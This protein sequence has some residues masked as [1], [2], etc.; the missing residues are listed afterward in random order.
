MEKQIKTMYVVHHAH[1]DIGYT[2]LQERV[3]DTQAAYIREVVAMMGKPEYE[4]FR[5]NCET[6][7]CVEEFF[8]RAAPKEK[9]AFC[10]LAREGKLGVSA[11]YLNFTDLLDWEVYRKRLAK[12]KGRFREAGFD[13]K[14]A[15]CADINGISMGCRDAML[16]NG[17]EFLLMNINYSHGMYPLYQNQNAWWWENARGQ[18]LLVWNGE[19][20]N[21]GNVLGIKPNPAENFLMENHLGKGSILADPVETLHENLRYYRKLC[22]DN[23]HPY[24]FILASVSGVFSDN[25]PP[26]PEILKNIQAYNEKYGGECRLQ[27]VSLQELYEA[28]REKLADAPVYHGDLTDWWANGVGSAPYALKHYKDAVYR[29]ELA[30]RLDGRAEEHY[31]ELAR[32]VQD[33]LMLYAEHTGGH[34][35][36]VTDPY[37]TMVMNLDIRKNS[38]ASKAH[39]AAS[40]MLDAIAMEKGDILRYYASQGTIKVCSPS[41]IGGPKKVEFYLETIAF[42]EAVITDGT[43]RVIPSQVSAHPRGRRITFVDTFAPFEEKIYTY[44]EKKAGPRRFNSRRCYVGGEGVRDIENTYDPVSFRLPGAFENRWFSLS[45][46]P[47]EGITSFVDKR[48]GRNLLGEGTAP[49]FT[50]LYEQTEIRPGFSERDER[51]LRG[52]NIRGAHAKLFAGDLEQ[53]DCLERGDVF[54]VLCLRWRLPGTIRA[55]VVLKFYEEIPRIDFKL[56]LGKTLSLDMESVYLPMSLS[57]PDRTLALRKGTEAFR[58]GIDQVPGTC[59]DYYISDFGLACLSK[60]GGAL[61]AARDTALWYMGEMKHHTIRLCDGKKE[62]NQRPVYSWVMNNTWKTNFKIDLSGLGEY[63]YTLWLWNG[64]DMEEAMDA[65]KELSFDPYV[66]IIG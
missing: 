19:H 46:A 55:D 14:T 10:R 9:E 25:A 42:E 11:N 54:T 28:I 26:E 12:W 30:R 22:Q 13:L 27:M 50:P 38:Y 48:A 35:A 49:F 56:M 6:L 65:V 5:W 64:E 40:R 60:E 4:A 51:H 16:D 2:D 29:Y 18:R 61:I 32:T 63:C 7:F 15:M 3:A 44:R 62:N 21:L 24:D 17:I 39:E 59:M 52:R 45:Y 20:Y 47:H 36:T 58:P 37:D 53:I 57:F 1:T 33:N 43:G 34:S 31:P 23:G 8:K 66:L 41:R